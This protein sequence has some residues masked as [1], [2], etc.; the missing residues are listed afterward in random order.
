MG[1]C[2]VFPGQGSQFPGMSSGLETREL[3]D[4]HLCSLMERGPGSELDRTT[5]AQPAILAVSVLLWRRSGLASPACVMGHS[6]GEYAALVAAGCLN[7]HVAVDVVANRARF[8]EESMGGADGGMAAVI[9]LSA[10]AIDDVCS[11]LDDLWVANLNGASQ[12]V[13]AGSMQSIRKATALLKDKGAKRVIPLGVRVASHCPY[14]R[15]ARAMLEAYLEG[16]EMMRPSCPVISN[17]SAEPEDDPV[18]IKALLGEQL[19]SPVR[20][21]ESVRRAWEMGVDRFVEIGPKSV[22]APLIRRI[23]PGAA[24]EALT[25]QA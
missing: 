24:V 5:N 6:L 2:L 17:V 16:V 18:R 15:G 19:T 4:E 9:G 11:S 1:Y 25:V 22:L 3:L 20:F 14:M 12:V 13:I 7:A 10:H 23:L 21:E 8:M